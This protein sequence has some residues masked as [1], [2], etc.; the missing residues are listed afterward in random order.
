MAIGFDDISINTLI[1]AG[2]KCTG[3]INVAGF[4]RIDGDLEGDIETKGRIIVGETARILGNINAKQVL[5]GGLVLGNIVAEQ[6]ATLFST[7]TVIGDLIAPKVQI[8]QD[9]VFQGSCISLSD[10]ESFDKAKKDWLTK[11][12]IEKRALSL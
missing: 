1:G 6:A 10:S 5:V 3:N 7:A 2:S 12:S 9:V 8:E 11:T 4:V